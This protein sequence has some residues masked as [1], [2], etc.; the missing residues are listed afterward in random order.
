[1]DHT[2]GRLGYRALRVHSSRSEATTAPGKGPVASPG[3]LPFLRHAALGAN[4]ETGHCRSMA[5]LFRSRNAYRPAGDVRI[6]KRHR[7]IV[8]GRT[9]GEGRSGGEA[10]REGEER[11]HGRHDAVTDQ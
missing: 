8:A 7:T 1:M 2:C 10:H 3:P 6:A 9:A 5:T 4:N 11:D